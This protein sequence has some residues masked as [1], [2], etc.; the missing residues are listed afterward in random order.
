MA[1]ISFF[2]GST[3]E[4]SGQTIAAWCIGLVLRD[5]GLKIGFMKPFGPPADPAD[6][7]VHDPDQSLM[8]KVLGL[9]DE[10]VAVPSPPAVMPIGTIPDPQWM[11]RVESRYQ[12]MMA[13]KDAVIV[14]GSRDIFFDSGGPV[15]P[16]S[17]FIQRQDVP[18]LLMDRFNKESLSI[19]SVLAINS[20]LGGRV[21]G[22]IINRVP[23]ERLEA[24]GSHCIPFL[25]SK[26]VN[27]VGVVPEDRVLSAM[28]VQNV[29]E[30]LGGQTITGAHR[31]ENLVDRFALGSPL[32]DGPLAIFK[33]V[34]NKVI[35]LGS[36]ENEPPASRVSGIVLTGGRLCADAVLQVGTELE[37]PLLTLP[38]DT[39]AVIEKLEQASV[40][41]TDRD[42]FRALRFKDWLEKSVGIDR[43]I[44]CFSR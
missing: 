30:I 15:L 2:I 38:M 25:T 28:M 21:R 12:E 5:R 34:Y 37:I 13:V 40:R 27:A 33:R 24:V 19:Y 39:F 11:A 43:L 9:R 8:K 36:G 16:D 22:V 42:E 26:G 1:I 10:D 35:L 4:G 32:L 7:S 23:S 41:L 17:H 6:L 44:Q 31:M 20:F 29:V 18:V 14:M 3:G